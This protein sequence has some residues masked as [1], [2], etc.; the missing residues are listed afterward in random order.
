VLDRWAEGRIE[1][2]VSIARAIA[3]GIGI[4]KEIIARSAGKGETRR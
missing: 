1:N 4:M 3:P 2:A